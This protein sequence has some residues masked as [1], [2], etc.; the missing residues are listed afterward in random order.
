MFLHL[1]MNKKELDSKIRAYAL[2]NAIAYKGKAQQGAVISAL[3]NEGLKKNELKKHLK[4]IAKIISEINKL[5]KEN[6]RK[7]FEKSKAVVSKRKIRQGLP[8]LPN[9]KKGK[10]VMRFAPSPSGA[11]HIGHALTASISFLYVQK[12]GGKF[13]VR[14]E[15]TNPENIYEPAYKLIKQDSDWLFNKKAKIII[16][17]DRMN[18][19]YKYAEKLIGK[20]SAYICT[21]SGDKFREYVKQKKNCPCRKLNAKQNL[22]RWKKMLDKKEEKR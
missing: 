21:C 14:I 12:Y 10:V 1:I 20:N 11:F 4:Q 5:S 16:Q 22:E 13:Y 7:E 6:Q 2:K 18:L 15:D 8:N 9:A 19:Y 17:S 3:F